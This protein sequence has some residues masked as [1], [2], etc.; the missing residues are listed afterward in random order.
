MNN[1]QESENYAAIS[2]QF[3]EACADFQVPATR[4][5]AEQILSQFRQI[6]NVLPICQYILEHAQS[7]MVQF[8]VALAAG[9]VAV[10]EYTLYDLPY[11]SQLK[12]YLLDY[13]L[14]RPK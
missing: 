4:A 9:D 13:C 7:P 14:Q 5:A 6:P 8:Q 2:K 1:N 10:R 11:L 12:H 3:E